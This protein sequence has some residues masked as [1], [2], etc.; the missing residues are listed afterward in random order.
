[1]KLNKSTAKKQK[2]FLLGV[3]LHQIKTCG[4]NL[5]N[6]TKRELTDKKDFLRICQKTSKSAEVKFLSANPKKMVKHNQ[7][8]CRQIADEFFECVWPFYGTGT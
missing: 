4:K 7:K 1:M 5:N 3:K 6:L 2:Y 8:I